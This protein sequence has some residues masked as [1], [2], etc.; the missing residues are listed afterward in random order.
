MINFLL[1]A[2]FPE[3]VSGRNAIET[4]Y[5]VFVPVAVISDEGFTDFWVFLLLCTKD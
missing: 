1:D 2:I 4:E 3:E 5:E